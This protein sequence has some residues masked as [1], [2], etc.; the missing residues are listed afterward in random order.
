[1]QSLSKH[2]QLAILKLIKQ[3][4]PAIAHNISIPKIHSNTTDAY[5]RIYNAIRSCDVEA[6][7]TTFT[8]L[9]QIQSQSAESFLLSAYEE[10]KI[11]TVPLTFEMQVCVENLL[12]KEKIFTDKTNPGQLITIEKR[13][14]FIKEII[15]DLKQENKYSETF[16]FMA[17]FIAKNLRCLKKQLKGKPLSKLPWEEM[18]FCLIAFTRATHGLEEQDFLTR[19]AINNSKILKYLDRFVECVSNEHLSDFSDLQSDY[20]LIKDIYSLNRIL[21]YVE[22]AATAKLDLTGKL[23]IERAL[24]VTGEYLKNTSESLH[25]SKTVEERLLES[26]PKQLKEIITSLR[27]SLSHAHT[28]SKKILVEEHERQEFFEG[29]QNDFKKVANEIT[30]VILDLKF[31][32]CKKFLKKLTSVE[33]RNGLTEICE[34]VAPFWYEE[35]NY[36]KYETEE[37]KLN[38]ALLE[39]MESDP[40][41]SSQAVLDFVNSKIN[42]ISTNEDAYSNLLNRIHYASTASEENFCFVKS[43]LKTMSDIISIEK[44]TVKD[45]NRIG[46]V[47][48]AVGKF[49]NA[50]TVITNKIFNQTLRYGKKIKNIDRL[51]VKV[52]EVECEQEINAIFQQI[53]ECM[54]NLKQSS[55]QIDTFWKKVKQKRTL[56]AVKEKI[57]QKLSDGDFEGILTLIE[58][59][60]M[61]KNS[62]VN[63]RSAFGEGRFED[64][65]QGIKKVF[66]PFAFFLRDLTK[67]NFFMSD[68]YKSALKTF[69]K[70]AISLPDS[71]I[72]DFISNTTR[73]IQDYLLG[74]LEILK[75][76]S[77]VNE[78]AIETVM[79]DVLDIYNAITPDFKGLC[80][81]DADATLLVGKYLRNYL[82]HGD[83]LV[84]VLEYDPKVSLH[85]HKLDF[86]HNARPLT[87]LENVLFGYEVFSSFEE[88]KQRYSKGLEFANSQHQLFEA[89][90]TGDVKQVEMCLEKGA[91]PKGLTVDGKTVLHLS[92]ASKNLNVFK[93]FY[94]ENTKIRESIW[95]VAL[96]NK[97][98][99]SQLKIIDFIE[100]SSRLM[101]AALE[102][103][104][105]DFIEY[106]E[107]R[108]TNVNAT[109]GQK[110]SLLH[111]ACE[112]G[113]FE[114]VEALL[115]NERDI[116][117]KTSNNLTPLHIASLF[118][119]HKI[120]KLLL[121]RNAEIDCKSTSESTPLFYAC[122][123]GHKKCVEL[124]LQAKADTN[125]GPDTPLTIASGC[126]HKE[127]VE[128]L[129]ENG[130]T[131]VDRNSRALFEAAFNGFEEIVEVLLK[132]DVGV[133]VDDRFEDG[134][135]ALHAAAQNGHIEVVRKLMEYKANIEAVTNEGHTALFAA[136]HKGYANIVRVFLDYKSNPNKVSSN[137]YKPIHSASHQGHVEVVKLLCKYVTCEDDLNLALCLSVQNSHIETTKILLTNNANPNAFVQ[138]KPDLQLRVTALHSAI[139]ENNCELVAIL[140]DAGA[141]ITAISAKGLISSGETALH[142]AAKL[143][144]CSVVKLLL[145][146]FSEMVDDLDGVGK[147]PM[148]Y[149]VF[150]GHKDVVQ[151]LLQH[152]ARVE[153]SFL[154]TA[155]VSNYV[156]VV[157][158]LLKHKRD[159]IGLDETL[160]M[161][162][163]C[164]AV[165]KG[166]L[167]IAD[168]LLQYGAR[169]EYQERQYSPLHVACIAGNVEAVR[170]LLKNG[171]NVDICGN[172]N[173]TLLHHFV[174]KA[175]GDMI[176]VLLEYGADC[177]KSNNHDSI[178]HQAVASKTTKIAELIIENIKK[179]HK[180][181]FGKYINVRDAE[182]DTPLMWAAEKGLPDIVVLLLMNGAEVN[183]RNHA[184][185]TA[186][187]WAVKSESFE[188]VQILMEN[189]GT[190]ATDK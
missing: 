98:Q 80:F 48:D 81:F 139:L 33:D 24:Q 53:E 104:K 21:W 70:N 116:N 175:Q 135:T 128:L 84:D 103:E 41:R 11:R 47:A 87:T 35:I 176:K 85:C 34:E 154:Q 15:E 126:G 51:N 57:L 28:L 97:I 77:P 45:S 50:D 163:M 59:L 183:L 12:L 72:K 127:I 155:V 178:L 16:Y 188:V 159:L 137:G 83:P 110:K 32:V 182:G 114:L 138:I 94:T 164:F 38:K 161:T 18:E 55:K 10:L 133:S 117:A 56:H 157:E 115:N 118:G 20:Y 2:D 29:I 148:F 25:I 151:V 172:D 22:H 101:A 23:V 76:I 71:V 1:M 122:F 90:V 13:I 162:S 67:A 31:E 131:V 124:L 158:V 42:G 181:D 17:K 37:W 36:T 180:E 82:A 61:D 120:V 78:I 27:D 146:R 119:H 3:E 30:V 92:A 112:S 5:S 100:L 62:T 184:G 64:L 58:E 190:T 160:K 111:K 43:F 167:D 125:L 9:K 108:E 169:V 113:Y 140:L 8:E 152:S 143:G 156:D 150:D 145:E 66:D 69:F 86:I 168:V 177:T 79:L 189:G 89:I 165:Q 141:L 49:S 19:M 54:K 129:L 171:A 7:E 179:S 95:H 65:K 4:A 96:A 26:A 174:R 173:M 40:Q 149:A 187:D 121:Q 46:L 99:D 186:L 132:F 134:H 136:A 123:G 147:T 130:V 93:M 106:F 142:F 73:K 153:V 74:R 105:F 44:R 63:F 109:I 6:F 170:F 75:S 88:L 166:Y 39:K 14:L 107:K 68:K 185:M 102:N 60:E 91:D 52:S 144:H